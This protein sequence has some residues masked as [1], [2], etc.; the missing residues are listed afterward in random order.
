MSVNC[1]Q[2]EMRSEHFLSIEL[3]LWYREAM[4]PSFIYFSLNCFREHLFIFDIAV[5]Y[6]VQKLAKWFVNY[7]LCKYWYFSLFVFFLIFLFSDKAVGSDCRYQESIFADI[8]TLSYCSDQIKKKVSV[9]WPVRINRCFMQIISHSW[10]V[11][12][13]SLTAR[14]TG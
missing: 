3:A 4:L 14:L 8:D 9:C 13:F 11:S 1:R 12:W 10:Q 5:E 6:T 7:I 2:Q